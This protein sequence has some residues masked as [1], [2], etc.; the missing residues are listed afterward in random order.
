MIKNKYDGYII[1]QKTGQ[2]TRDTIRKHKQKPDSVGGVGVEDV[3]NG[4]GCA[5]DLSGAVD[6][7]C[8]YFQDL[9][10]PLI[11]AERVGNV[12]E[13]RMSFCPQLSAALGTVADAMT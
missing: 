6:V 10:A 13:S 4:D 1:N 7:G 8:R 3:G 5:V 2:Q 9:S 11:L 12:Y